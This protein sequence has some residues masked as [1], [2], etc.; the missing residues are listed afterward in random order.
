[1]KRNN[2][3]LAAE[4]DNLYNK[5]QARLN[6]ENVETSMEEI[7][8]EDLT[9]IL[10]SELRKYHIVLVEKV[11]K[12][13]E[14][15]N[16]KI[17]L[18]NVPI[19]RKPLIGEINPIVDKDGN[20]CINIGF[21]DKFGSY[22][23]YATFNDSLVPLVAKL[24]YG[25][26]RIAACAILNEFQEYFVTYLLAL[27]A[28][29]NEYPGMSMDFGKV[30]MDINS[31]QV[32]DDGFMRFTVKAANPL[33]PYVSLSD[34]KESELARLN[35]KK[36]SELYDYIDQY[37]QAFLRKSSVKVEDLNPLMKA[38]VKHNMRDFDVFGPNLQHVPGNKMEER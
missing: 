27:E 20:T 32:I 14:K 9:L 10:Y 2:D 1:M 7:S 24:K 5:I 37:A 23:G 28:F 4:F 11:E 33:K 13:I 15:M 31:Y 19:E 22:L 35:S 25:Y 21:V 12:D 26:D 36:Y 38:I 6:S 30:S 16:H 17:K 3:F 18:K 34:S 8:I 29:K